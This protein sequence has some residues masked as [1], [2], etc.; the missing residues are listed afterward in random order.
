MMPAGDQLDESTETEAPKLSERRSIA[1]GSDRHVD[2]TPE[3]GV[4][5]LVGQRVASCGLLSDDGSLHD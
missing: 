3:A 5:G 4:D 2:D 1:E